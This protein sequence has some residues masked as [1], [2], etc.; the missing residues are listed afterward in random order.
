M[1]VSPA[2]P[3][4]NQGATSTAMGTSVSN[5]SSVKSGRIQSLDTL[6]GLAILLVVAGHYLPERIE[7]RA[8]AEFVSTWRVGGVMLFF[9]ISG[10][11]IEQT[12]AKEID[13][14]VYLLRRIFRIAPAYW[15]SLPIIVGIEM[16]SGHPVTPVHV[17]VINALLLQD[18]LASPLMNGVFWTLLIETKFYLIAPVIVRLGSWATGLIP[19][20]VLLVNGAILA[21]RTEASNL[22]NYANICFVG[23]NFSLWHRGLISDGRLAALVF[24]TSGSMLFFPNY[25]P[26]GHAAFMLLNSGLLALALT[27]RFH[28]GPVAFLGKISYSWYLYHTALGYPLFAFLAHHDSLIPG[29]LTIPVVIAITILASWVSYVIVERPA[30]PLGRRLDDQWSAYRTHAGV[31][32]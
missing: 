8:L 19:F 17:A 5:P 11:L 26:L 18:I 24:A 12:L 4:T 7:P 32:V 1:I 29:W 30:I 13:P 15:V 20:V 3:Q 31:A 27:K 21:R 23:M 22:L 2:R 9:L 14:V 25:F 6:R 10:F 16:A 28:I